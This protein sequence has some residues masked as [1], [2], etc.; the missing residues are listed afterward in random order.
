MA[1]LTC[2]QAQMFHKN[3][4]SLLLAYS[5]YS[6]S[7]EFSRKN[8]TTSYIIQLHRLNTHENWLE[9]DEDMEEKSPNRTVTNTKR[10]S[11]LN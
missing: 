2:K 1:I 9:I 6:H 5:F 10:K 11:E 4:K 7:R 3:I 8:Y